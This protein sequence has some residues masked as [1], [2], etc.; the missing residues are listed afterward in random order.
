M[1]WT[2]EDITKFIDNVRPPGVEPKRYDD[3]ISFEDAIEIATSEGEEGQ[4][5]YKALQHVKDQHGY[6]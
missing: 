5:L 2:N 3:R 1:I 6:T 4:K